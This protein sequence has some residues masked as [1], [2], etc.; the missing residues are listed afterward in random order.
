MSKE[1]NWHADIGITYN[2]FD[3]VYCIDCDE[4]MNTDRDEIV[5][6]EC[7]N[8]VNSPEIRYE[9]YTTNDVNG[10]QARSMRRP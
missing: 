10:Y 3:G 2:G 1:H 9:F 8:R 5:P 4:K 6:G 7:S